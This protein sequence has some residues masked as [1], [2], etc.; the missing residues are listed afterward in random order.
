MKID[1]SQTLKDHKSADIMNE[2]G[3][4]ATLLLIA[5]QALAATLPN[6]QNLP[7]TDKANLFNLAVKLQGAEPDFTLEE[8]ALIKDRIGRAYNQ[9]IV[10]PAWRLL[11]AA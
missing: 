11:E 4:P 5:S 6:D 10:G 3:K 1:F 8:L 2:E 7:G 9:M